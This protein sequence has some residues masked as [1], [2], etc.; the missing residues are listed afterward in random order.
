MSGATLEVPFLIYGSIAVEPL[1]D[2][3]LLSL[4]DSA[5]EFNQSRGI[6]GLL[7]YKEG[8]FLQILEGPIAELEALYARIE[9]DPRH[10]SM[11]MVSGGEGPRQF[12]QWSMGFANITQWRPPALFQGSSDIL[13]MPF[14]P[15]YFGANPTQAQQLLLAFRGLA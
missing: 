5:R 7:L 13:S 10:R 4:L 8:T 1:S 15:D 3:Q 6:T 12:P 9:K 11:T 14:R 2:Q